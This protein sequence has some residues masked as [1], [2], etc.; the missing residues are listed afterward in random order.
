MQIDVKEAARLLGV[1]EKTVYRWIKQGDLPAYRVNDLYRFNRAELLEWA[2]AKR[3]GVSPEI[4]SDGGADEPLPGLEEAI[5][6]GGIH[7]RVGGMSKAEV[8]A[9]VVE[10][11]RLPDEVDRKFLLS[12]ILG[13]ESLGSTGFGGGIA[14]PHV[15]NPIVLHIPRPMITLCFLE[16]PIE[17]GAIDGLP[18]HTLFTLVSPTVRA[19]LH[20]LSRLTYGLRMAQFRGPVEAQQ[21]RDALLSG[22]QAVDL[23]AMPRPA[24]PGV[25][26]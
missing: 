23:A 19:H 7:Y 15:R 11:M 4:F 13:R 9:S 24:A 1:S 25:V 6:A 22:A 17:F 3:V 12:V 18:V 21:G 20:L 10:L 14:I 16:T 26:V 5:R 2:T 8:L